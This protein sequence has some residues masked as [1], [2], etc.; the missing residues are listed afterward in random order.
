M[1]R[2]KEYEVEYVKRKENIRMIYA[3]LINNMLLTDNE[4]DYG[5]RECMTHADML[6]DGYV[7]GMGFIIE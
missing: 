2:N 3:G 1:V 6:I 7:P 5:Y 4:E